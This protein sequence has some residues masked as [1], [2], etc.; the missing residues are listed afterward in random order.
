MTS[1]NNNAAL[2]A[3]T[4]DRHT[5]LYGSGSGMVVVKMKMNKNK[6]EEG[7]SMLGTNKNGAV[8]VLAITTDQGLSMTS[9]CHN[10][11]LMLYHDQECTFF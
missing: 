8:P 7:E 3:E 11:T 1:A 5:E 9:A 10:V 2:P 6:S 4:I